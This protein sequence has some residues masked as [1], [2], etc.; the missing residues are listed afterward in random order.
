MDVVIDPILGDKLRD[1]QKE[2]VD[3]LL[4]IDDRC[5]HCNASQGRGIHVRGEVRD[6]ILASPIR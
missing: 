6:A 3:P 2:C 1:H 4:I 5:A